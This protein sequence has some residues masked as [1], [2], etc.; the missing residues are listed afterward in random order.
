M[1]Y[2]W[3]IILIVAV[4]AL[5]LILKSRSK[6]KAEADNVAQLVAGSENENTEDYANN[7]YD[8]EDEMND[9]ELIAV[10]MAAIYAATPS[11]IKDS[12]FIQKINRISGSNTSWRK[13]GQSESIASRRF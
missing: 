10:I 12:L 3:I 8:T 13:A 1:N 9:E 6:A 7:L 4:L 11:A 5:W 2:T